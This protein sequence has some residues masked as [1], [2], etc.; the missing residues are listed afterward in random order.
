[1]SSPPVHEGQTSVVRRTC[2]QHVPGTRLVHVRSASLLSI[3]Y[4][5]VVA[6][7]VSNL[8]QGIRRARRNQHD[9]CPPP[10][11]DVEDGVTDPV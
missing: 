2:T 3:A 1:M 8:G 11:L 6:T 5:K 10:Q 7:S 4:R 9:V